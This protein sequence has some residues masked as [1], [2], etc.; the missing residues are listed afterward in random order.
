MAGA[1]ASEIRW[2]FVAEST[3]GTIPT[4]PSFT[5]SSFNQINMAAPPNIREQR[6]NFANRR[7]SAISRSGY[8]ITGTAT[9]QLIYGE[10]DPLFESLLQGTWT[11]NVLKDTTTGQKAFSFEKRIPAGAGGTQT[12]F[13]Y[14]GVEAVG[15]SI[16]LTADEDA[17]VEMEFIGIGA[18]ASATSAL[19][20]ATYTDPTNTTALGS[21]A[22]VGFFTLGSLTVPCMR[23]AT[24]NFGIEDKERQPRVGSDDLCGIRRGAANP[25]INCEL[26]IEDGVAEIY[27][28]ARSGLE[29]EVTIPLGVTTGEKYEIYFPKCQFSQADLETSGADVF[30]NVTILPMYDSATSCIVQIT[31]AIA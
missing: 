25:T 18:N 3:V 17:A 2:A 26:Y 4:S 20:G 8:N 9:G 10:Y 5:V 24:I 29:F 11:S 30:Q 23:S 19:S 16:T 1:S 21:G 27:D 14:R 7:R 12:Y 31:R 13:R 15:G 28:A 22:D 6:Q